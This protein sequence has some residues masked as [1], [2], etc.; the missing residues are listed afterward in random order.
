M[1]RVS[2]LTMTT[3]LRQASS[4]LAHS[5]NPRTPT[6]QRQYKGRDFSSPTTEN[7]RKIFLRDRFKQRCAEAAQK[8]RDSEIKRKRWTTSNG[9][10]SDGFD[11]DMDE[12]EEQ[13]E[14][15]DAVLN[16]EVR[17]HP[18]LYTIAR[19]NVYRSYSDGSWLVQNTRHNINFGS[20]INW[21]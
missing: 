6:R 15:Q 8:S 17:D 16:D 11:C 14:S 10:S 2:R 18:G 12:D 7:P 19:H 3:T 5:S 4:P 9:P 21:M 20:P 1:S 13:D